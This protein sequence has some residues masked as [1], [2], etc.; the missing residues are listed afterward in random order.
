MY[1]VIF[2][3]NTFFMADRN[4]PIKY[5]SQVLQIQKNIEDMMENTSLTKTTNPISQAQRDTS[6]SIL[7]Y[8]YNNPAEMI[9]KPYYTFSY[10][11]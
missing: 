2:G 8:A 4:G 5:I 11:S 3:L 10:I 6:P 1:I 7:T 9:S